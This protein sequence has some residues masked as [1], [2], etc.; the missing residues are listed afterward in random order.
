MSSL[1]SV[2]AELREFKEAFRIQ[3]QGL[4]KLAQSLAIQG[5][6]LRKILQA[7]TE[8]AADT[9][10]LTDLLARLA[11]SDEENRRLLVE[12]ASGVSRIEHDRKD[13]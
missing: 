5:E 9:S 12:I 13:R 11:T 7:V 2:E 3:S 6:M 1:Q 8:P 10:P 4:I